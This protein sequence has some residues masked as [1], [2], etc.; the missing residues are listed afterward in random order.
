MTDKL[1]SIIVLNWN[2]LHY[3][4]QTIENIIKNTTIPHELIFVDNGSKDGT[5]EYLLD[6]QTKTNAK[7]VICQFN[8]RNLGV[9]GGRNSGIVKATGD[10][11]VTIDDDILVPK[12]WDILMVEACD[13]IP[14]LGITG[15]NVEPIKF[16]VQEINGTK[17]RPKNGNLGG[18]CLCIPRR[19]FKRVGY[20]NYFNN[21][22]HEDAGMYYRL[23][24]LGLISA[25][26]EPQGIHLDTDA[27][28]AY[29]AAKNDAHKKGSIQLQALASYR[30]E[31]KRTGNVYVPF[32]PNFEPKDSKIFTN[33]LILKERKK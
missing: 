4:K 2:R 26:I 22:G 28:K 19:V 29:R 23:A 20:Y 24:Y 11:L 27:D 18:A 33:D 13:K 14:K 8:S 30:A 10:Y 5:R 12:D 9:A 17:V 7:N 3:S 31:L 15:V 1:M 6:M 25:Y 21:Y 16:P 32:D